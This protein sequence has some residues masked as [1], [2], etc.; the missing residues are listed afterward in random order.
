MVF[1][2]SRTQSSGT[3]EWVQASV[4][5]RP[6]N[7]GVPHAA[8]PWGLLVSVSGVER[9]SVDAR[10]SAAADGFRSNGEALIRFR[11]TPR[12]GLGLRRGATLSSS[13]KGLL[14]NILFFILNSFTPIH[15]LSTVRFTYYFI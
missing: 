2:Y 1:A 15:S 3:R 9:E 14:F 6:S 13:L 8:C 12:A 10:G 5:G 11:D 4:G 7:A